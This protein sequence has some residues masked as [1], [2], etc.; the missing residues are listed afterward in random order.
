M[1]AC[2]RDACRRLPVVDS[3]RVPVLSSAGGRPI[4]AVGCVVACGWPARQLR[5]RACVCVPGPPDSARARLTAGIGMGILRAPVVEPHL[6]V[7]GA[8]LYDRDD[9]AVLHAG[10]ALLR[11]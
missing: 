2:L 6:S 7:L 4:R 5:I 3:L 10:G 9:G 1:A 8:G 11:D